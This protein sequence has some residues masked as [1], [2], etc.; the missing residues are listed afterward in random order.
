MI[1]PLNEPRT[2]TEEIFIRDINSRLSKR[3]PEPV[4]NN[5]QDIIYQHA[6]AEDWKTNSCTLLVENIV[7]AQTGL[8]PPMKPIRSRNRVNVFKTMTR[9][10]NNIETLCDI[11]M[12]QSGMQRVYDT[13]PRHLDL[14]NIDEFQP[15]SIICL[16]G[17]L[18]FI[19][20]YKYIEKS[21]I[22]T[23]IDNSFAPVAITQEGILPFALHNL[24][25][26]GLWR[27]INA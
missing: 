27:P 20:G 3:K 10:F 18:S 24:T 8:R 14:I 1:E 2:K 13:T 16:R 11:M 25:M 19:G 26:H 4:T 6:K 15:G 9:L 5:V 7:A 22:V 21:G 17:T 12:E 23:T